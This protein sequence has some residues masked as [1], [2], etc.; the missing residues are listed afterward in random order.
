MSNLSKPREAALKTLVAC[1]KDGAYL[2]IALRDILNTYGMEPRDNALATTIA[3]GV[4][5]NT[6]FL[7]NI[8]E[9]LSSVKIKKL[10]VWIHNIL[11]IGIFCNRFLDRIPVSATVNE[12]VRLARRYGHNAS[13][14]YVNAILR[15][16]VSSGDFL[17]EDNSDASYISIKYSIPLW[18]VNMWQNQGY[19]EDFFKAMN[20][21]PPVTV[22]L[23]TI[24]ADSLPKEF[25][26]VSTLAH[27]YNYTGGGSVE[28]HPLYK[29][30]VI[31]VQDGASQRAIYDFDIEKGSAVLDL[32]SAPGGKTA[33]MSQLMDNTGKIIS[34]DIHPHKLELIKANLTRLGITNTEVVLND[35]TVLNE[36]FEDNFDRVLA[37]VPCSGLGVLRRKPDIKRT[38]T[39]E[40]NTEIIKIQKK[41][42]ENA[43]LYVKKGGKL[44]YSTC[45][46]NKE[47]N[48]IPVAEFLSAH[49][50]FSLCKQKQL[51]PHTDN[52]DGFFY[53]ILERK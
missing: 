26:K 10:S 52:T 50:E 23:N 31:A 1:E 51:L 32:C 21:E 41:I 18:L 13:A 15:A 46:V 9:N 43:A 16:S 7:D 44:M 8:I 38:K 47:E 36:N 49:P 34:C 30:G 37:D 2:N 29:D 22:R 3:F 20:L 35:A 11:R 14:G 40:D 39:P 25:E 24:K 12:C 45:T 42:L 5:K 53:A 28:N 6:I 4:M 17:P 27:G 48:E 33:Y 19:G